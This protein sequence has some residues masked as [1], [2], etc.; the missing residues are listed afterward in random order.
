MGM[1]DWVNFEIECPNCK[2]KVNGFQTK[3]SACV[4][5]TLEFWETNN[6]Y[7]SC[8]ECNTWMEFTIKKIPRPN[9]KITIKDYKKEVKIPTK[10]EQRE[11]KKK[12]QEF[13][14]LLKSGE[15]K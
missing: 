5:G 2:T 3:D 10:K 13:A 1:F 12:Y 4:M 9:R 6:F 14:N 7:A 11:H 8:P 15:K